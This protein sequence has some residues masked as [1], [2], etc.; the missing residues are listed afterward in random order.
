MK[1]NGSFLFAALLG[2]IFTWPIQSVQGAHASDAV[3]WPGGDAGEVLEYLREA[4]WAEKADQTPPSEAL[5]AYITQYDEDAV[6]PPP[7]LAEAESLMNSG[8]FLEAGARIVDH[9]SHDRGLLSFLGVEIDAVAV[10]LARKLAQ[11]SQTDAAL[12]VLSAAAIASGAPIAYLRSVLRRLEPEEIKA[13]WPDNPYIVLV[14]FGRPANDRL[15][16]FVN[17]QRR[18]TVRWRSEPDAGGSMRADFSASAH[19]GLFILGWR[20]HFMDMTPGASG[21][22]VRIRMEKPAQ[23]EFVVQVLGNLWENKPFEWL[24]RIP[25]PEAQED[26]W[27][28]FDTG[29]VRED[30]VGALLFQYGWARAFDMHLARPTALDHARLRL[31][32]M[33]FDMPAGP[34]NSC[35]IDRIELYLP[36]GSWEQEARMPSPS[37][38]GSFWMTPDPRP[39]AGKTPDND[40]E[41]LEE[42]R[43]LGYLGAVASA[44]ADTGISIYNKDAAWSGVN[45]VVSGHAPELYLMDMEGQVLHR[46]RPRFEGPTWPEEALP[47]SFMETTFWRRAHLYPNGDVLA[48]LD[49]IVLIKMDRNGNILWAKPG[50]YHH[51]MRVMEDDTIYVLYAEKQ[52]LPESGLGNE[53][54]VDYIML[55]DNDGK[56]LRRVSLLHA[57]E[58]S[59]YAPMLYDLDFSYDVLHTNSLQVLD[60]RFSD[61]LPAFRE[62]NVLV[63]MLQ[64]SFIAVVDMDAEKVVWGQGGQWLFPHEPLLLPNGNMLIFD[65]HGPQWHYMERLAS[66]VLE[67]SPLTREVVWDYVGA[68]ERPFY[69]FFAARRRNCPMTIS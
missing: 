27:L 29:T 54:M 59:W 2:A 58:N 40:L 16:V 62:G 68:R 41:R 67:F 52:H 18:E 24:L 22:R 61:Q 23:V 4:L 66:R 14:D 31:G 35:W 15:D 12:E 3:P 6:V 26:G 47:A 9:V 39:K 1:L 7:W 50:R 32:G 21:L 10:P 45:F 25:V 60:G 38:F 48:V 42:L 64:N 13:L 28:Y 55:L 11:T 37:E 19:D 46:W 30:L 49:Y 63:C 8:R 33:G 34:A 17:R 53:A 44:P 36:E 43:A 5:R 51:Q 69:S 20:E 57:L 65:N 56:E